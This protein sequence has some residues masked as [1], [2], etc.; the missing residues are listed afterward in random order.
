MGE[1]IRIR[2]V[3]QGVGFRPT[4][5]RVAQ[6]MGVNGFVRNEGDAVL[7][8]VTGGDDERDAFLSALMHELPPLARV[9]AVER[10]PA[11]ELKLDEG[12]RIERSAQLDAP[13]EVAADAAVCADCAIEVLDPYARRFRYPLVTCTN[14]GPRYSI[15]TGVPFDRERTTMADFALC[16][17]CAAEFSDPTDRR[18]H[19][20][21]MACFR[22]GPQVRLERA[23]GRAFAVDRFSMLDA[24]DAVGSLLLL[25]EI[26]A[27]KGLG[28]YHLCC[29]ATNA[30]AVAKLR[31]RKRR[32]AKPFA[33]M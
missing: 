4:V 2:G 10:D 11:P 30:E 22:C 33:L 25:G 32:S 13:T 9:D 12:F 8:G 21:A 20:Q 29:Y 7:I 28:G 5:V 14:C 27:V 24:V 1:R 3:V 17:D 26:V 6:R 23:D 16:A 15:A 31:Q 19:A 18:F